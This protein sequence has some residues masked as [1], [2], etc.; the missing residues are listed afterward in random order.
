MAAASGFNIRYLFPVQIAGQHDSVFVVSIRHGSRL[1]IEDAEF[2]M[3]YVEEQAQDP[4]EE[5]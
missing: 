2:L 1:P 4:R 3:R 5:P